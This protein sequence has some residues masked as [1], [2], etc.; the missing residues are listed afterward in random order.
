MVPSL[1]VP[2]GAPVHRV[3]SGP[4][5]CRNG[6]EHTVYTGSSQVGDNK[7]PAPQLNRDYQKEDIMIKITDPY[8]PYLQD[9]RL[10]AL[11]YQ[12]IIGAAVA[13]QPDILDAP[14]PLKRL[15]EFLRAEVLPQLRLVNVASTDNDYYTLRTAIRQ[16]L[17]T[18]ELKQHQTWPDPT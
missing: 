1:C 10:R 14:P 17:W 6:S 11:Q 12:A 4:H 5:Q 8:H 15:Q 3:A 18:V 16:H 9:C 13:H 2:D 7:G